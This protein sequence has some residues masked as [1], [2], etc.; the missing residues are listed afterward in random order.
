MSQG[1]LPVVW[2]GTQSASAGL[3]GAAACSTR[4]R[5]Y[6]HQVG[7]KIV[8]ECLPQERNRVT[9][10]DEKDQYGLPVPRVTYSLCDNDKRLITHALAFMRQALEAVGAREIW[11][12]KDDTCHLNGTARM[13]DDPQHQRRRR[14]LPLLGHSESV[15]LRRIGVSDRRRREP[16]AD[17][18]GHRLPHRRPDQGA[19]GAWR[20]LI[21]FNAHSPRRRTRISPKSM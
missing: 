4:W 16:V 12:E 20:T 3:W 1:P 19:G 10:T 5:R 14:R 21:S 8:G 6:N 9:L 15:D 13:G 11:D 17:D 7:L 2:A 18:P